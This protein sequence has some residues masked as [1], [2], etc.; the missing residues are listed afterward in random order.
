MRCNAM[1][2]GRLMIL[3]SRR[4]ANCIFYLKGFLI[5]NDGFSY[6]HCMDPFQAMIFDENSIS[7]FKSFFS[8]FTDE[9]FSFEPIPLNDLAD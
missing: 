8:S 3:I 6:T 7:C 4:S 5:D 9:E 2:S 1:S